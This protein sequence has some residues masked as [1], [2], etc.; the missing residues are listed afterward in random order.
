MPIPSTTRPWA[1]SSSER[2]APKYWIGTFLRRG[3]ASASTDFT[4]PGTAGPPVG[5]AWDKVVATVERG[6]PARV[7][8]HAQLHCEGQPVGELDGE[9]AVL[10][11]S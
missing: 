5:G 9:F 8:V 1:S 10:P 11:K 4:F 2:T 3:R 6:R 7:N